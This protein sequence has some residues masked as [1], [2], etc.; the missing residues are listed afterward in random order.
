MKRRHHDTIAV[1]VAS[2]CPFSLAD[3][4]NS[5]RSL[6][7]FGSAWVRV[8]VVS[9]REVPISELVYISRIFFDGWPSRQEKSVRIFLTGGSAETSNMLTGKRNRQTGNRNRLTGA[10]KSADR[11]EN[12]LTGAGQATQKFGG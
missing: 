1:A 12:G 2:G 6:G 9:P 11:Q 5:S 4:A 10:P 3:S 8:M 7:R